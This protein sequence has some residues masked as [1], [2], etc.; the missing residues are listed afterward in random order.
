MNAGGEGYKNAKQSR[1]KDPKLLLEGL[2]EDLP[3]GYEHL[4]NN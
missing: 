2:C 4:E 1:G 3:R